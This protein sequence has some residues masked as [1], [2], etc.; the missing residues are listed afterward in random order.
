V[1]AFFVGEVARFGVE[2]LV[3]LALAAGGKEGGGDDGHDAV[4]HRLS[5][6][7]VLVD[8]IRLLEHI[9]EVVRGSLF[10]A[11]RIGVELSACLVWIVRVV[12]IRLFLAV[13]RVVLC[14]ESSTL[15]TMGEKARLLSCFTDFIRMQ[16]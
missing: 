11:I 7:A 2:F 9:L 1:R 3:E 5:D 15:G 4:V 10:I 13:G 16:L 6:D 12:G 8:G 14:G